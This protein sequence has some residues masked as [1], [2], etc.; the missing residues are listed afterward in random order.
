MV[1]IKDHVSQGVMMDIDMM[2][3]HIL[4]SDPLHLEFIN[5]LKS[6]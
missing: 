4:S 5:W 1:M 6:P 3:Y 2:V